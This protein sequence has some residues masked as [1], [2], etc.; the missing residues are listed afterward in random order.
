MESCTIDRAPYLSPELFELGRADL[1][2]LGDS[3]CAAN[4]SQESRYS[5][6]LFVWHGPSQS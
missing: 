3:I 6:E 1:L 2:T 5:F 4:D